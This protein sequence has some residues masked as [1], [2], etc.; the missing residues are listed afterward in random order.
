M[1]STIKS[2]KQIVNL[3]NDLPIT[4]ASFIYVPETPVVGEKASFIFNGKGTVTKYEWEMGGGK[5]NIYGKSALDYAQSEEVAN[6]LVRIG[7]K[8]G[9]DIP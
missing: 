3:F 4:F 6:F 2:I 8:N 7:G 9:K 5:D 1:T